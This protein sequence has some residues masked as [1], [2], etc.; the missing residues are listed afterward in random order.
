M[1]QPPSWKQGEAKISFYAPSKVLVINNTPAVHAQ[2][3]EFLQ[4]MRKATPPRAINMAPGGVVQAQFNAPDNMRPAGPV[5][6][7]M[8][9]YPIPSVAQPPKHLFHFI[10]RYEGAGIVD[11]NVVK[12]VQL[13]KEAAAEKA[14]ERVQPP[15]PGYSFGESI[16]NPPTL[17]AGSS[18]PTPVYFPR[19]PGI[20][21]GDLQRAVAPVLGLQP[22]SPN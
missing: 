9:S 14:P 13:M 3:D 6:G 22:A 16:P 20:P 5:P 4:N 15:T 7:T 10:I 8:G 17:A 1:V 19:V 21:T 18:G 12:L 2:M 11:S